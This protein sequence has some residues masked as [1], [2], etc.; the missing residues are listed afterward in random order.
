[1]ISTLHLLPH[2]TYLDLS[3]KQIGRFLLDRKISGCG[4]VKLWVVVI[5][6]SHNDVDGSR[7]RL[8]AK[9]E[10]SCGV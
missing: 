2:H 7:G 8:R 5:D 3:Y 6:I 4:E 10:T 9:T 1:M